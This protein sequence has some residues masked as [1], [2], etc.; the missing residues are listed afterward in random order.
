MGCGLCVPICPVGA[1][2]LEEETAFID[3]DQCVECGVCFRFESCPANCFIREE[4]S[5]PRVIR[6]VFSDPLASHKSTKIPGRGTAEMKTNDVTNRFSHGEVGL[7]IELGRPGIATRLS[8]V[9]RLTTAL[10]SLKGVDVKYESENPITKLINENTG[11]F[12]DEEV[13]HERVLSAIIELKIKEDKA[14]EVLETL[15]DELEQLDT[16]ASIDFITREVQVDGLQEKITRLIEECGF[17]PR[18][19]GKTCVG[20]GRRTSK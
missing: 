15:K 3:R 18:L 4:L 8:E 19:N 14:G 2:S 7:G 16:V 13:L 17:S 11:K 9:E 5:W 20:L 6:Y 10:S 12:Q 1:I